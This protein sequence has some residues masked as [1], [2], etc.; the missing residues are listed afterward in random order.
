MFCISDPLMHQ[1][2]P[3]L[4]PLIIFLFSNLLIHRLLHRFNFSANFIVFQNYQATFLSHQSIIFISLF[5]KTNCFIFPLYFLQMVLS[6]SHL[7]FQLFYLQY[8]LKFCYQLLGH[9]RSLLKLYSF[10]SFSH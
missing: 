6:I 9:I 2:L 3:I 7:K 10:W 4:L 1:N 5:L 8:S